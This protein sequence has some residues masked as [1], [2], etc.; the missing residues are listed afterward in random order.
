MVKARNESNY[1]IINNKNKCQEIIRK[2]KPISENDTI[3]FF[4]SLHIVL[5]ISIHCFFK[6]ILANACMPLELASTKK[7]YENLDSVNF[8]DKV[9]MF[10]YSGNF[11]IPHDKN[12]EAKKHHKIIGKL[13]AFSGLRNQLLHG[14][15]IGTFYSETQTSSK[16]RS[17]LNYSTV[18]DQIKLYKEIIEGIRFFFAY[19]N[20]SYTDSGKNS[21]QESYLDLSFLGE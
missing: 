17:K 16:L 12:D 7:I 9:I 13:R 5:E 14:H 6:Q 3:D 19:L 2:E 1:L 15:T 20:C 11:T 10:I 21:L 4:I 8:I 18:E